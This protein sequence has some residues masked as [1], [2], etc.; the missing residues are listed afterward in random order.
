MKTIYLTVISDL[1]FDQRMKRICRSL[2]AGGYRVV[3]VGRQTRKSVPLKSEPYLQK[4]LYCYFTRGKLQYIEFNLKLFGFLLFRKM[5]AICAID[6]DTIIPCYWTS[7]IKRIVR[8]YDAHELFC[9]MQE[10][11]RRPAI[12]KFWKIVER[13]YV[14]RFKNGY[15][16][17]QPIANEFNKMYGINYEVIRNIT[18]LKNTNNIT[19]TRRASY[20]LYQGSVN[21][22]R[23]FDTLIPAMQYV[24][25][26]LWIC[27]EGNYMEQARE[28]T[29]RYQLENK[30]IFKG[31]VLPE[32]LVAITEGASIGITLFEKQGLSNYFSLANRFFDY[33]HAGVPQLCVDYPVYRQINNDF[34]VACLISDLSAENI[35]AAINRMLS[36]PELWQQLHQN[37]V[38]AREIY[39]W[40]EEE[41]KLLSFYKKTLT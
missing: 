33:I 38:K 18:V 19:T 40:Q 34:E 12:Y 36:N 5:D 27:G 16:V 2:T 9:E 6:L 13:K 28:L 32:E 21:E 35:A 10:I 29:R 31:A 25:L 30:I 1:S 7:V 39:N 41:K 24:D 37:C 3:L 14:P 11:V 20:I 8:I 22:G 15:T 23:S 26:P 17:N 4:R